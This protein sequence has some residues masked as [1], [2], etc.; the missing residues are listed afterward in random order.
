MAFVTDEEYYYSVIELYKT[1]IAKVEQS[2]DD[3]NSICKTLYSTN[4]FGAYLQEIL[5]EIYCNFYT[6]VSGKLESF[7]G[8]AE[9]IINQFNGDVIRSDSI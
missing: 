2:L 5:Q 1:E 8:E 7:I 4:D 3:F 6:F 9:T